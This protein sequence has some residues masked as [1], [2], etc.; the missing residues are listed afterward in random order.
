M[1]FNYDNLCAR[2]ARARPQS[3]AC[4][5]FLCASRDGRNP[6]NRARVCV[7]F[8][9][10]MLLEA[11]GQNLRHSPPPRAGQTGDEEDEE[12]CD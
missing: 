5:Q 1:S 4:L 7:R 9:L 3:V 10:Q 11:D 12:L 8:Y 6:A 2:S